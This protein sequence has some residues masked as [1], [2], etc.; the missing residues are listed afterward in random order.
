MSGNRN[1]SYSEKAAS[2]LK[3]M[4]KFVLYCNKIKNS[5]EYVLPFHLYL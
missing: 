2:N 4:I 5:S 1:E 3:K